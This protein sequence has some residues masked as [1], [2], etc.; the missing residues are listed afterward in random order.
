MLKDIMLGSFSQLDPSTG[1]PIYSGSIPI[2]VAA[3]DALIADHTYRDSRWLIKKPEKLGKWV[4]ENILK[5]YQIAFRI[6]PQNNGGKFENVY[7]PFDMRL[8][9]DLSGIQTI[10]EADLD[11]TVEPTWEPSKPF[12]NIETKYYFETKTTMDSLRQGGEGINV[13]EGPI[14]PTL[15]SEFPIEFLT[16]DLSNVQAKGGNYKVDARG[17]RFFPSERYSDVEWQPIDVFF[18]TIRWYRSTVMRRMIKELHDRAQFRW[19]RGPA[20]ITIVADRVAA[21]NDLKIGE[22]VILGVDVLPSSFT[23]TRGASRLV[24]VIGRDEITSGPY[25]KFTFVDSGINLQ[26]AAPI[27]G[28]F[29]QI[30]ATNTASGTISVLQ[31]GTV[32]TSFAITDQSVTTAP[33]ETSS[34]WIEADIRDFT[35]SSSQNVITGEFANGVNVFHRAFIQPDSTQDFELPS[36]FGFEGGDGF[37]S[38]TGILSPPTNLEVF[39]ISPS[40]ANAQWTVGDATADVEIMMKQDDES[41]FSNFATL[42]PGATTIRFTN[43]STLAVSNPHKIL[44]RHV[45]TLTGTVSAEVTAS[46]DITNILIQETAPGPARIVII[47]QEVGMYDTTQVEGSSGGLFS[48]LFTGIGGGF[49]PYDGQSV[50]ASIKIHLYIPISAINDFT[51]EL[52]RRTGFTGNFETIRMIRGNLFSPFLSE[53]VFEMTDTDGLLEAGGFFY[54]A[55]IVG[56]GF[57]PFAYSDPP[58]FARP[59]IVPTETEFENTLGAGG[60][61]GGG[62]E[63]EYG[64]LDWSIYT[65]G[66]GG[67]DG[68]DFE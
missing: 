28:E 20:T 19:S 32:H 40:G 34:L 57:N 50:I 31:P 59:A 47:D 15:V 16:V 51:L 8:P 24:Q 58:V 2:D 67:G 35:V 25:I 3:F 11:S 21:T 53:A 46:Y 63:P 10:T 1:E 30:G 37:V 54:R 6:E 26:R 9:K 29:Q 39:N 68:G 7:V 14:N 5:P 18:F 36:E 43:R 4:E 66:G 22:Y 45:D 55:R 41:N 52:Q 33:D 48:S 60:G 49:N 38:I 13:T 17:V 23:H 42:P 65:S 61:T 56:D 27:V 44:V 62:I 64:E 12:V